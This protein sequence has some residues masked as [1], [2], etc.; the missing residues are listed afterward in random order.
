M[1]ANHQVQGGSGF[2]PFL[3]QSV[4][5]RTQILWCFGVAN[6]QYV[7]PAQR[8]RLHGDGCKTGGDGIRISVCS[9]SEQ[10]P[11]NHSA[12]SRWGSNQNKTWKP[13]HCCELDTWL[14]QFVHV[15]ST[16]NTWAPSSLFFLLQMQCGHHCR[17][18]RFLGS[19]LGR[20]TTSTA[21]SSAHRCKY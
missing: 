8:A 14:S 6:G 7:S 3:F 17:P 4:W 1:F 13:S 12:A 9:I 18:A 21:A 10:W 5:D 20:P 19:T 2:F 15:H 16:V 11:P